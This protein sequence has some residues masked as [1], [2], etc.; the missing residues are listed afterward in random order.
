MVW[1]ES[2]LERDFIYLLEF[3]PD[4][5]SFAEQPFSLEYPVAGKAHTYTPDFQVRYVRQRNVL[6]ECK[7]KAYVD[8]DEN[9]LKF[10]AA[11]AWC[12]ERGWEF[13]VV[14]DDIVRQGP[15]LQNIK[16]LTRYARL[17][18]PPQSQ[19]RVFGA[20]A[21]TPRLC[22]GQLAY[23]LDPTDP[24]AAVPSLLHLA[25]HHTIA[26]ALDEAPLSMDTLME[27][28]RPRLREGE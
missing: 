5:V 24:P 28:P 23:V 9:R 27:L 7:P 10:R 11:H 3:D 8:T 6:V 13:R 25:F 26:L 1:Y 12:A 22:L 4:V 20:L 14:T 15:R 21:V 18:V 17:G 19:S 2:F 16:L